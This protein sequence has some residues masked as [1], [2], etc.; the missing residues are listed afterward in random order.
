[1]LYINT[2]TAVLSAKSSDVTM[3][4]WPVLLKSLTRAR[5]KFGY[6]SVPAG[7][8]WT[9]TG[10]L[11]VRIKQLTIDWSNYWKRNKKSSFIQFMIPVR[12]PP[13][14]GT[15][16]VFSHN[17]VPQFLK[18][19]FKLELVEYFNDIGC[20]TSLCTNRLTE[21]IFPKCKYSA[22]QMLNK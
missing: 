3:G 19:E 7:L 10:D 18:R 14:E 2:L 12:L 9:S 21:F 15:V 8:T 22:N 4:E 13:K 5:S 1:M 17:G 20:L 11:T 16:K 6:S